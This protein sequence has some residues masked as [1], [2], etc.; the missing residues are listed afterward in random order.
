MREKVYQKLNTDFDNSFEKYIFTVTGMKT[1]GRHNYIMG[2]F[3]EDNK[4]GYEEE[5]E[6]QPTHIKDFKDGNRA[7]S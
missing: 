1:Y 7:E 6:P 3:L 2:D 5:F 4:P